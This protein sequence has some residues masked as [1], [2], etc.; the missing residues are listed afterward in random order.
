MVSPENC[1]SL[2]YAV[3]HLGVQAIV[4]LGHQSCGAVTAALEGYDGPGQIQ[5]I[6]AAIRP[7]IEEAQALE[8]DPLE[9]AVH[10]HVKRVA[11]LLATLEPI[12]STA[13]EGGQLCVIPAHYRLDTGAVE[14][15]ED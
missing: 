3:A 5:S 9:N 14:F 4:V 10:C 15:F 6:I 13:I 7:A 1:G 2:E 8:G 11:R 12:L